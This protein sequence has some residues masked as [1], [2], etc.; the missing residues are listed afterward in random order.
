MRQK[1]DFFTRGQRK[2]RKKR[3]FQTEPIWKSSR[4]HLKSKE[5]FRMADRGD[6]G[7]KEFIF[8]KT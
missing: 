3:R 2:E 4:I 6:S 7:F 8:K 5:M 1:Y